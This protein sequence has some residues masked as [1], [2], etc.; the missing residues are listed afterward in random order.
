M[1]GGGLWRIYFV[2]NE[3]E[4]KIVAAMLCGIASWQIDA[5]R[6]ACQGWDRIDQMLVPNVREKSVSDQVTSPSRAPSARSINPLAGNT[7]LLVF[8]GMAWI[9]GSAG[10]IPV[11]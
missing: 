6:I 2:E 7:R 3:N 4:T 9:Q 5:T 10:G 1:S 8:Q 11:L